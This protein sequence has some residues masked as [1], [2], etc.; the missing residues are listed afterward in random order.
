MKRETPLLTPAIAL[1]IAALGIYALFR[2][3]LW[4]W[5]VRI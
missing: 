1:I 5:G 2:A 3:A 4:W